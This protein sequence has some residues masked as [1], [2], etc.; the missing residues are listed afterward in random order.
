MIGRYRMKRLLSL[1]ALAIASSAFAQTP[2]GPIQPRFAVAF[3][4]SGNIYLN[5]DLSGAL[6]T[7]SAGSAAGIAAS[8]PIQPALLVAL[9]PDGNPIYLR[10]DSNGNLLVSGGGG[11]GGITAL[12]QDV[13]ASGTG[14]VAATVVGINGVLLSGLGTGLYKFTAGVP[15]LAAAGTDYAGPTCSGTS[16]ACLAGTTAFSAAQT[17]NAGI[18]FPAGFGVALNPGASGTHTYTLEGNSA[19]SGSFNTDIYL[20]STGVGALAAW[21]DNSTGAN[22]YGYFVNGGG[23]IGFTNGAA[24]SAAD[25]Y[26]CRSAAGVYEFG[27]GTFSG[28]NSNGSIKAAIYLPGILYSAAGTA[29]PT[30][31]SGERGA[32]AVVSDATTPTYMGSYTSGGAVTAAVICSYNGTTYSWLTH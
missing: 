12:T 6:Y 13:T 20:I 24:N 5:A 23:C 27:S 32:T 28:P 18:A 4:P 11:G 9:D 29:L 19:T 30:C 17:F 14:S 31:N 26:G 1:A 3:G 8:G 21:R 2:S 7:A 15:S 25:T 22:P 16:Y 10:A